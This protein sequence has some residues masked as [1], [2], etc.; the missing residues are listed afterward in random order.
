MRPV[1]WKIIIVLSA[2]IISAILVIPTF[3]PDIWPYKKINLGLDLQGGMHL[4]MEV[5]IDKAVENRTDRLITELREELKNKRIKYKSVSKKNIRNIVLKIQN[6]ENY[7]K[8][9][10]FAKKNFGELSIGNTSL[11]NNVKTFS[12]SLR[13]EEQKEIKNLL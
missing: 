2:I 11:E 3:S 13:D 8:F 12:L 6:P 10:D 4:M 9:S 7:E 1:P 5:D